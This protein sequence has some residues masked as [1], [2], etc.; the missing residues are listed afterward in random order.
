M[1]LRHGV[2]SCSAGRTKKAH[3][4]LKRGGPLVASQLDPFV[5]TILGLSLGS[6]RAYAQYVSSQAGEESPG[7]QAYFALMAWKRKS[8]VSGT[9][10]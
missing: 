6:L 1:A 3:C 5:V 4:V 8:V 7:Q 9:F 10:S 2:T